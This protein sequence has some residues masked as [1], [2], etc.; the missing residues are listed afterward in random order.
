MEESKI[1][2]LIKLLKFE[3]LLSEVNIKVD[4]NVDHFSYIY[5]EE[6][7]SLTYNVKLDNRVQNIIKTTGLDNFKIERFENVS[8]YDDIQITEKFI[9]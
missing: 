5:H 2:I 1:K 7:Y 4:F 8:N 9:L 3:N 6:Y